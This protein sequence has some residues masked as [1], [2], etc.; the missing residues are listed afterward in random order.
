MGVSDLLHRN[1][2][3]ID[4]QIAFRLTEIGRAKL[5]ESYDGNPRS[6][7]LVALE[8]SG[9]QN[10]DELRHT[11]GLSGSQLEQM[12]PLLLRSGY[13]AQGSGETL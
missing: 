1:R 11:S 10:M 13:V 12:L 7:I 3:T 2:G 5:G 6:R 4:R 8:C 9:S